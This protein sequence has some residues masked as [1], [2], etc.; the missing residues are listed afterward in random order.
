MVK[1]HI[2][3]RSVVIKTRWQELL[4]VWPVGCCEPARSAGALPPPADLHRGGTRSAR[5]RATAPPQTCTVVVPGARAGALPPPRA[6]CTAGLLAS[7][8]F[9]SLFD[10]RV[11]GGAG[12]ARFYFRPHGGNDLPFR[13][14]A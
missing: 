4:A 1:H 2:H 10:V 14:L 5:G 7:R 13:Y 9:E 12:I 11:N 3:D 6:S 8:R